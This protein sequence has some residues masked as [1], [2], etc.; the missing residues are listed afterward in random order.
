[1]T[2]AVVTDVG[3]TPVG[4]DP[5]SGRR[6]VLH[7][8]RA[9]VVAVAGLVGVLCVGWWAVAATTGLSLVVVTTGSM[10]PTIPAGSVV[11]TERVPAAA[12][13]AGDVVTVP[14]AGAA[15]PVTHRVV[16]V[17][18]VPGDASARSLTTRGDAN[19]TVDRAPAVVRELGRTVASAPGVGRVL[20]WSSTPAARGLGVATVGLLVVWSSW[21]PRRVADPGP[22]GGPRG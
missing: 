12:V 6:S 18:R 22:G 1:M 8:V 7:R 20:Q 3:R 13:R 9:V 14:R 19:D 11:V 21:P 15:L 10:S 4:V 2:D 5:P 16:A 17:E